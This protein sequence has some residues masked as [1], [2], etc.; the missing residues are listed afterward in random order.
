MH[1]G[2][3]LATGSAPRRLVWA[4]VL[5]FCC[6][7]WGAAARAQRS[8]VAELAAQSDALLSAAAGGDATGVTATVASMCRANGFRA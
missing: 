5:A 1:V 2:R 8:A 7:L 3:H 6:V 4:L